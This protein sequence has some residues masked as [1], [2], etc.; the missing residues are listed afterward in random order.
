MSSEASYVIG[1]D[2]GSDSVR[3]IIVNTVNGEELASSVF[4]YPRWKKQLYCNM[5]ENQFRQHPLDYVEGLE[6]TIKE[7]VVK[8][9]A[10]VAANI[11]ALSVDTTG[12]TPV[13]VDKTGTPLALTPGFEENPNAMFVLW[14]DH[15]G[16]GE[17]AEI[18]AH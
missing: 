8:V 6:A 7:C 10:A 9:G 17:A 4:Y 15:T 14:K 5:N 11:K 13:A 2:Y 16:V 18:N 12:S 3:T 1:V